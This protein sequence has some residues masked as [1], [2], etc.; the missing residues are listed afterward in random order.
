MLIRPEWTQPAL[1]ATEVR[2]NGNTVA[3]PEPIIPSDFV[4]QLYAPDQ[5]IQVR[6]KPGSWGSSAHWEFEL[7]QHTFRKPSASDLDRIQSDPATTETTPKINFRWKRDGKLSRDLICLLSGKSTDPTGIKKKSGSKEPDIAIALFKHSREITIYETNLSRVEMEDFKGL[8]VVLLLSAAVIKDVFFGNLREVFNLSTPQKEREGLI[9]EPKTP[10]SNALTGAEHLSQSRR[11]G[12][13]SPNIPSQT[14]TRLQEGPYSPQFSS[15]IPNS[16]QSQPVH[17]HSQIEIDRETARLRAQ[18]E[19][20]ERSKARAEEAEVRRIKKMLKAEE[21]EARRRQAEIDK[22]SERLKKIYGSGQD[23]R[24]KQTKKHSS[25]YQSSSHSTPLLQGPF[26]RAH[27]VPPQQGPR[28]DIRSDPQLSNRQPEAEFQSLPLRHKPAA[29][30]HSGVGR[31][32]QPAETRRTG[33]AKKKKSLFGLR[34][35]SDDAGVKLSKQK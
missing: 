17:H 5:A 32:M 10:I 35:R 1:P 4:I 22:E 26:P 33:A 2:R 21:K 20:E 15:S 31:D 18:L 23:Q 34:S 19:E 3:S 7:P 6:Q 27:S 13:S 11:R 30:G 16:S 12:H 8:E 28:V 9:D 24:V 29:S 25:P 14:Q